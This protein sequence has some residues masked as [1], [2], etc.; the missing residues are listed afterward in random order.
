MTIP[1]GRCGQLNEMAGGDGLNAQSIRCTGCGA[2][3][4]I[5]RSNVGRALTAKTAVVA[6]SNPGRN[7]SNWKKALVTLLIV[8]A[9]GAVVHPGGTFATFSAAVTNP[10]TITTGTVV[11]SDVNPTSGTC[12][13]VGAATT[14]TTTNSFTCPTGF[15]NIT[16]AT[17]LPTVFSTTNLPLKGGVNVITLKN[18]GSIDANTV[19]LYAAGNCNVT[20]GGGTYTGGHLATAAGICAALDLV[21]YQATD[22]TGATMATNGCLYGNKLGTGSTGPVVGCTFDKNTA[23]APAAGAQPVYQFTPSDFGA[24]HLL[25]GSAACSVGANGP[26]TLLNTGGTNLVLT[27]TSGNSAFIVIDVAFPDT[28]DQSVMGTVATLNL[29]FQISQ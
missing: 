21:I 20:A 12:L 27:N 29:T 7:T 1:C 11:L 23:S 3:F 4:S 2:I 9:F 17:L 6:V 26:I 19:Q 25:V 16:Q 15:L 28:G 10:A 14:I 24:C 18:V 13:S 8:G 5:G 22:A